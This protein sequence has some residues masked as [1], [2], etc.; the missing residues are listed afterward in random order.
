MSWYVYS[1]EGFPNRKE[2]RPHEYARPLNVQIIIPEKE[3]FKLQARYERTDPPADVTMRQVKTVIPAEEI[4]DALEQE[5]GHMGLVTTQKESDIERQRL[6]KKAEA[7]NLKFRNKVLNDFE[8]GRQKAIMTTKGRMEP[9]DYELACYRHLGV[10][11]PT[12]INLT[13]LQ[14]RKEAVPASAGA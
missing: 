9:S 14:D 11:V 12:E 2:G 10:P 4:A 3:W 6:E 8:N 13:K 7:A 1:Q 5:F